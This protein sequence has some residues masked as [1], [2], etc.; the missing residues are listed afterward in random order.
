[1][2]DDDRV[3]C[4][5]SNS[6]LRVRVPPKPEPSTAHLKLDFPPGDPPEVHYFEVTT[7]YW[8]VLTV[9]SMPYLGSTKVFSAEQMDWLRSL[10]AR[11]DQLLAGDK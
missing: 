2:S 10:E 5:P 9:G 11:I 8:S 4:W 6:N 3:F 1:M 7:N